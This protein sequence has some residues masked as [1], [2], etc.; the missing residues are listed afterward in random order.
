MSHRKSDLGIPCSRKICQ[1][2]ASLGCNV[3]KIPQPRLRKG[4]PWSVSPAWGL[5]PGAKALHSCPYLPHSKWDS[6]LFDKEPRPGC[7]RRPEQ[8]AHATLERAQRRSLIVVETEVS[9][10]DDAST[11]TAHKSDE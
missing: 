4:R 9:K 5:G 7:R 2:S 6:A 8:L 3:V 11:G 10:F 1:S